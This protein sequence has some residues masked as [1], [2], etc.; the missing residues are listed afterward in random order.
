MERLGGFLLCRRLPLER[1]PPFLSRAD[2]SGRRQSA[3]WE[4][5]RSQREE[6]KYPPRSSHVG[7]GWLPAGDGASPAGSHQPQPPVPLAVLLRPHHHQPSCHAPETCTPSPG[8]GGQEGFHHPLTPSPPGPPAP[9]LH[10]PGAERGMAGALGPEHPHHPGTCLW[11]P[12]VSHAVRMRLTNSA[13]AWETRGNPCKPWPGL[14]H[15]TAALG[16]GGT[17]PPPPQFGT[18]REPRGGSQALL[19]GLQRAHLAHAGQGGKGGDAARQ[20]TR[21]A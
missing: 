12:R 16:H 5:A 3:G 14:W 9:P 2:I 18:T 20:R 19:G 11:D 15:T 21:K 4:G 7:R 6:K 8:L 10:L 17:A 13:R 1:L